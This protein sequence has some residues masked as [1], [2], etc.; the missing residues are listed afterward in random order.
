[1]I[2]WKYLDLTKFTRLLQTQSLHFCR[3]DKFEDKFEG[4]YPLSVIEAFGKNCTGYDAVAWRKFVAISCWFS[5]AFDSDAMWRLYTS[6][7]QGVAIKTSWKKLESV[8]AGHAYLTSVE[9][10]DFLKDQANIIIPSDVFHYK[11]NAYKHENE[12]RAIITHYP[13]MEIV[14]GLPRNSEPLVG[15]E[16]PENG[17]TI[18][19]FLSDLVEA[20]IVTPYSSPWFIEVVRDL[21]EKYLLPSSI[22]VHSELKADPVYAKI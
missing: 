2:L 21:S 13:D 14:A 18:E 9:Y 5:G 6:H 7:N 15:K 19:F 20:I 3:G 12:V 10:I 17:L 11:R 1:M 16:I 4:S 22:V 8:V